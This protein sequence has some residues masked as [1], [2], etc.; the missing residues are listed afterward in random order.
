MAPERRRDISKEEA[1]K[2]YQE[3]KLMRGLA[4]TDFTPPEKLIGPVEV[5]FRQ[6]SLFQERR[7]KV[8]LSPEG[9]K[10]TGSYSVRNRKID[11][12]TECQLVLEEEDKTLKFLKENLPDFS[13]E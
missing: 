13:R 3:K 10:F 5:D 6:S 9:R 1:N 7:R 4:G 12:L 8:A 11:D 2:A